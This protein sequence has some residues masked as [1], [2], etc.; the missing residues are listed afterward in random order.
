LEEKKGTGE[1]DRI[2]YLE[3][4]KEKNNNRKEK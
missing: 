3:R 4:K 2:E 1:E